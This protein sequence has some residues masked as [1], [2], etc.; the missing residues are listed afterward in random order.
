MQNDR[1][2]RRERQ[3]NRIECREREEECAVDPF[4]GIFLR[5]SHVDQHDLVADQTIMDELWAKV[6]GGLRV[7][8][9]NPL[10]LRSGVGGDP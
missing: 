2:I 7:L 4:R 3:R 1:A 5:L 6:A 9:H 8:F 10:I